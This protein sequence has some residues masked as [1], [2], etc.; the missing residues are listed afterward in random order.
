MTLISV[1][2]MGNRVSML[3]SVLVIFELPGVE[4]NGGMDPGLV[5]V[6]VEI[7]SVL[8][9]KFIGIEDRVERLP[10][11]VSVEGRVAGI[12]KN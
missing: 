9:V 2:V 6:L 4:V 5:G 1:V 8:E 10:V 3:G 12:A 7:I 11:G